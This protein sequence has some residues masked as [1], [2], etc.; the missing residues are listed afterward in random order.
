LETK[1]KKIYQ[2]VPQDRDQAYFKYNGV[3]LKL[4]ISAS[5]LKYFQ[6]TIIPFPMYEHLIMRKEILTGFLQM[7]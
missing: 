3:L 7:K 2:P 5:G 4:L 6:E 1:D